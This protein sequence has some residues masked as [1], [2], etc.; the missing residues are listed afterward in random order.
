MH[1]Y[2]LQPSGPF[3]LSR[4]TDTLPAGKDRTGTLAALIHL[5]AGTLLEEIQLDFALTRVGIEPVKEFL[6]EKVAR[7]EGKQLDLN[8]EKIVASVGFGED[9]ME[10]F[11]EGLRE[12]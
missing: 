4:S 5:L 10:K 12:R 7:R 1:R 9:T 6:L 8:D 2:A 11:V 3:S